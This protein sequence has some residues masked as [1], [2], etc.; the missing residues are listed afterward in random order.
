MERAYKL[1]IYP[2]NKQIEL[3]NQTFGCVRY[4]YNYFLNRKINFYEKN[5]ESL[6]Y[7]ACSKELTRWIKS[8]YFRNYFSIPFSLIF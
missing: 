1:R 6:T 4:I 8:I 7:N 5:N 3:L 2:N